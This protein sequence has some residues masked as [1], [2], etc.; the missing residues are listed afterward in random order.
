MKLSALARR[1]G[2]HYKNGFWPKRAL[3]IAVKKER[4]TAEEY[5]IITGEKYEA[6]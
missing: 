4:I 2:K 1:Y 3:K 6:E 5:E